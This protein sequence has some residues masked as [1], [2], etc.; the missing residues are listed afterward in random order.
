MIE[1]VL[2]F[3]SDIG[4]DLTKVAEISVKWDGPCAGFYRQAQ[5][6]LAK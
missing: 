5:R 4:H 3:V 2:S 6:L 1:G